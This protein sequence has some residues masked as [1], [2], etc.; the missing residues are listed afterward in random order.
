LI[1]IADLFPRTEITSSLSGSNTLQ[2]RCLSLEDGRLQFA[3]FASEK[4][5]AA[6]RDWLQQQLCQ[7]VNPLEILAG[8]P[9]Q[10][11]EDRGP[12]LCACMNVG[13]NQISRF[14]EKNPGAALQTV[15]DA[16]SAGTG[17]GSCRM[18]VQ[19][20]IHETQRFDQTAV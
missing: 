10:A 9:L 2:F 17:C 18:E 19:R 7:T 3:F 15:C 5:V 6:S 4:P 14:V 16:T 20:V 12:I 1:V 11:G 13:R 8:R